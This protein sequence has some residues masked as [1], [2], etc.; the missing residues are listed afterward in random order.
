MPML[1]GCFGLRASDFSSMML[2]NQ[3]LEPSAAPAPVTGVAASFGCGSAWVV[4]PLMFESIKGIIGDIA[5][6]AIKDQRIALSQEQLTALESKL[7]SLAGELL[8]AKAIE[9]QS[10]AR[11]KKLESDNANING[12]I[13]RLQT[14]TDGFHEFAGVLWKRTPNGF[15]NTPYCPQ[16]SDHP[17]MFGQPPMGG[18]PMLWQCSKC[19]F[20]A[21]FA[22]RPVA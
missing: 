2:P 10:Q 9:K 18:N 1:S 17:V 15:G 12:K 6:G 5:S 4:R 22:G 11:I 16:C 19:G 21:D 3:A 7:V 20:T 14:V 13:E 8:N